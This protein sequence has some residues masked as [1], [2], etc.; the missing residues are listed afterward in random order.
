MENE[1]QFR[2]QALSRML[3]RRPKS[4]I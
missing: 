4:W 1:K 3:I 2:I